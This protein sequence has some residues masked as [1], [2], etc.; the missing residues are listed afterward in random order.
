[1]ST[2]EEQRAE[3][4]EE[5]DTLVKELLS[6]KTK[7]AICAAARTVVAVAGQFVVRQVSHD[8][9]VVPFHCWIAG[10]RRRCNVHSPQ[11][12]TRCHNK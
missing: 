7:A 2:F 6:D 3:S 1:M 5:N 12:N 4:D 10:G 9:T 11:G 8:P